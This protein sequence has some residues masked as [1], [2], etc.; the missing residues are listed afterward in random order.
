MPEILTESFCERCGTRYT[1]EAAAPKG[2]RLG[3]LKVFSKGFV[4]FVSNDESSLDEALA[5]ARSDEQRELTTRQLDAFHQTFQFC[6][7]CRQYTCA[8]CWNATESRCLSCAPQLG[9]DILAAPFPTLD[10]LAGIGFGLPSNGSGEAVDGNGNGERADAAWPS[11]DVAPP[12]SPSMTDAT[13]DIPALTAGAE[14]PEAIEAEPV[15]EDVARAVAQADLARLAHDRAEA[16]AEQARQAE[17]AAAA[18]RARAA[19]LAA[20]AELTRQAQA[21][22]TERLRQVAA[23]ADAEEALLA[24]ELE[25]AE[26]LRNAAAVEEAERVQLAAEVQ[27]ELARQAQ[28]EAKAER[29]RQ[30]Q[31]DAEWALAVAEADRLQRVTAEA[32]SERARQ[33]QADADAEADR[34]RQAAEAEA[35]AER[36]RRVAAEADRARE[37]AARSAPHAERPDDRVGPPIWQIIAPESSTPEPGPLDVP[38]AILASAPAAGSPDWPTPPTTPQWPMPPAGGPPQWPAGQ[39]AGA[40]SGTAG[41]WAASSEDVISKPGPTGVQACLSC[42]LPLSASARFCRRCGTQP[43]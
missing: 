39:A 8:T 10:P 1:F 18:E 19:E 12:G 2:K 38:P 11:T 20:E 16:E 5:D 34:A 15:D 28:A 36:A 23:E 24:K 26:R 33:A 29:V 22:E 13:L 31:A 35:E 7:S 30:A 14:A 32:E 40:A 37:A 27:A 4:N 17:A 41:L 21:E 3:K 43:H 6:L 9:Q 25:E 42:G